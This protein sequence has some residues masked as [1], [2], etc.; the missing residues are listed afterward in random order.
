LH[1]TFESI[2]DTEIEEENKIKARENAAK[3]KKK[4]PAKPKKPPFSQATVDKN[5]AKWEQM[6]AES[7]ARN[8]TE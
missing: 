1:R 7:K 4:Q 8:D 2:Y 6:A 3:W 5:A